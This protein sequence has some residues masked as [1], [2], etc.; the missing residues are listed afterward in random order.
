MRHG[1]GQC[2]MRHAFPADFGLYDLHTA[3]FADDTPVFH[4][5]VFAAITFIVFCRAK[6]FCAEQPIAFGF[7]RSV[8][9]GF[10]LL[11]LTMGPF[12]DLLRR[13]QGNSYTRVPFGIHGF[14]EKIV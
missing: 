12:E 5:F 8:I 9:N 3:L 7:K 10:R 13:C 4:P 6:Y 1:T 14:G 11:Y 2:D